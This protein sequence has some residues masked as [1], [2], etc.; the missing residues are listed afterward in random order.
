LAL[1]LRVQRVLEAKLR[2]AAV[3]EKFEHFRLSLMPRPQ[4]SLFD[5]RGE[6]SREEYLR[7]V[8]AK[9]RAFPHHGNDFHYL[10]EERGAWSPSAIIGRVGRKVQTEENLP[11]EEGFA[12]TIHEGWKAVVI[13]V[14]PTDHKDGQKVAVEVRVSVGGT[15]ALIKGLVS[16]IND[17]DDSSPYLIEVQPIFDPSEFWK[18][19]KE[20]KGDVTSVKFDLVAPNGLFGARNNLRDELKA[21]NEQSG[22]NEVV[23]EL[24]NPDGLRLDSEPIHEAVDYA[25]STGGRITG[26]AKGKRRFSS[27][28]RPKMTTL[29]DTDSSNEPLVTRAARLLSEILGH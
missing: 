26:K 14:D 11:P 24:K 12:D 28:L 9:D 29:R 16:A 22:A 2:L 3:P 20:N 4:R 13:V 6:L 1:V 23:I 25:E 10:P 8:F 7:D 27:T 15:N 21:A 5:E 19:A 18:W 17:S